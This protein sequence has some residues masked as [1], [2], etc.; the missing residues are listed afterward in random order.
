MYFRERSGLPFSY[1]GNTKRTA[2][3]WQLYSTRTGSFYHRRRTRKI[4]ATRMEFHIFHALVTR[5]QIFAYLLYNKRKVCVRVSHNSCKNKDGMVMRCAVPNIILTTGHTL[6]SAL[7][8]RILPVTF[9][10]LSLRGVNNGWHFDFIVSFW[11]RNE[12]TRSS[13]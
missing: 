13:F 12:I 3:G 2:H 9:I 1:Y 7:Q 8:R 4:L 6:R 11:G 5:I 10:T